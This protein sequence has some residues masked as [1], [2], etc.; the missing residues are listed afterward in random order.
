MH[1]VH[2]EAYRHAGQNGHACSGLTPYEGH[3]HAEGT[4][5]V[6]ATKL[7]L[8][9]VPH[10]RHQPAVFPSWKVCM[11]T[12]INKVRTEGMT[13][14][15]GPEAYDPKFALACPSCKTLRVVGNIKLTISSKWKHLQCKCGSRT[16]A[17]HW[18]CCHGVPWINCAERPSTLNG[19]TA[20]CARIGFACGKV[21]PEVDLQADEANA[22]P[23]VTSRLP[24]GIGTYQENHVY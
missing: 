10:W 11:D 16:R 17:R 1:D 4:L 12:I 20:S 23:I 9:A 3:M 6:I 14:N 8:G 19:W 15:S 24:P 5:K 18:F 22:G 21:S 7:K 2:A 13:Q